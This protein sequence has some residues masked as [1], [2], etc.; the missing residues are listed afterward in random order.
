VQQEIIFR[1]AAGAHGWSLTILRPGVIW[2]FRQCSATLL[3]PR[4]GP[5]QTVISSRASARVV[6]VHNA[7]AAFA[8]AA[9]RTTAGEWIVNVVNDAAMST[10]EYARMVK[11][12]N[13]GVLIPVPYGVASAIAHIGWALVFHT[14]RVP[15][16]MQP[17][18]VRAM[19]RSCRY[20]NARLKELLAAT[21]K[22][23]SENP[24][25]AAPAVSPVFAEGV[26]CA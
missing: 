1:T 15:Y 19:H 18:R 11:E 13:G 14:R 8:R 21:A 3:G 24:R 20:S 4:I 2:D 23:L 6:N 10:W 25:G 16:F 5:L 17:Q 22:P 9:E 7:A 12:R 26:S